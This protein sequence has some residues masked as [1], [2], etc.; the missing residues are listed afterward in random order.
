MPGRHAVEVVA[1]EMI[2][3]NAVRWLVPKKYAS[4]ETSGIVQ[5]ITGPTDNLKIE[6][7]WAGGKPFVEQ[8]AGNEKRR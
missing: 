2:G 4:Y 8:F 5:E 1:N 7:T 6:L 3:S